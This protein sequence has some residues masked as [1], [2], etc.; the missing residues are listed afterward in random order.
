MV[1]KYFGKNSA[2]IRIINVET[3]VWLIKFRSNSLVNNAPIVNPYI[4]SAMLLPISMVVINFEGFLVKI[5]I[6]EEIKP[7]FFFSISIE[8]LLLDI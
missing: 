7:V 8:I 5:L 1:K 6:I 4:T 3:S 2:V